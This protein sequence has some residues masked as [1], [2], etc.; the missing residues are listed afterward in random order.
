MAALSLGRYDSLSH[1]ENE[2]S[3]WL[4]AVRDDIERPWQAWEEGQLVGALRL[5]SL[6]ALQ[7]LSPQQLKDTLQERCAL[8]MCKAR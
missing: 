4:A 6:A 2:R 7:E 3:A 1:Y 8:S 5:D